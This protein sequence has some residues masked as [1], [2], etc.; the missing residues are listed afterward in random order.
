MP[1]VFR[2]DMPKLVGELYCGEPV[3]YVAG[4]APRLLTAHQLLTL[5]GGDASNDTLAILRALAA[6]R[7]TMPSAVPIVDVSM[8][9]L[10]TSA[11]ADSSKLI[12]E[13]LQ[14]NA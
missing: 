4:T 11:D 3:V 12:H 14:A 7:V 13:A 5:V 8:R 6:F 10:A 9:T 2:Y 1:Q